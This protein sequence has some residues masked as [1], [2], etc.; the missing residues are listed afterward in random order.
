MLNQYKY[1]VICSVLLFIT[2][3]SAQEENSGIIYGKNHAASFQ[4][5]SGWVLDN[6]SGVNQGV[7]AAIYPKGSNWHD[8]PAIMYA[9]CAEKDKK[10]DL[11]SFIAGDVESFKQNDSGLTVKDVSKEF[12]AGN[13]SVAKYFDGN[14]KEAVTYVDEDSV[15]CMLVL[16]AKSQQDYIKAVPAYNEFLSSYKFLTHQVDLPPQEYKNYSPKKEVQ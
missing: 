4:A 2:D 15:I 9:N 7:H 6:A 1:L 8:A 11:A 14:S 13:H 5:P 12:H 3:A 10:D 16:S